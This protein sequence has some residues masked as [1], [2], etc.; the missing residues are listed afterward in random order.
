M[1]SVAG[2]NGP[3]GRRQQENRARISAEAPHSKPQWQAPT[4][5]TR[6][7]RHPGAVSFTRAA[8]LPICSPLCGQ[9]GWPSGECRLSSSA[10]PTV[11]AVLQG[12]GPSRRTA[13]SQPQPAAPPP[14]LSNGVEIM[15]SLFVALAIASTPVSGV[16]AQSRPAPQ[17]GYDGEWNLKLTCGETM[18]DALGRRLST[19]AKG[20]TENIRVQILEN[21]IGRD[22]RYA[23]PANQS[24]F[25]TEAWSGRITGNSFTLTARGEDT[26]G[27]SWSYAFSGR[28]AGAQSLSGEGEQFREPSR[29]VNRQCS[30]EF[31]PV[32]PAPDSLAGIDQNNRRQAAILPQEG[33]RTPPAA[34]PA[35][36]P[37]ATR[38]AAT[39]PR[40][41]VPPV[42]QQAAPA[43]RTA[44]PP[45]TQRAAPAPQAPAQPVTQQGAAAPQA[46]AQPV[47]QLAAPAP[48]A[49]A[50][51]VTQLAAPAPQAPTQP[52]TQLAAPMPASGAVLAPRNLSDPSA[53]ARVEAARLALKDRYAPRIGEE[54]ARNLFLG[55]EGDILIFSNETPQA[56]HFA[57]RFA[58]DG[59]FR[60]DIARICMVQRPG[61]PEP[62]WD[63][64]LKRIASRNN[65]GVRLEPDQLT[66]NPCQIAAAINGNDLVGVPRSILLA[67]GPQQESIIAHLEARRLRLFAQVERSPF[68]LLLETRNANT[69]R[70][71]AELRS[72]VLNGV[73]LLLTSSQQA[74]VCAANTED[75][76]F[77]ARA[78][79]DISAGLIFDRSPGSNPTI[80]LATPDD[81]FIAAKAERCGFI[82]GDG[83]FLR[84]F[85]QALER[86]A[87]RTQLLPVILPRDRVDALLATM[88]AEREAAAAQLSS[89][90]ESDARRVAE[91]QR[92]RTEQEAEAAQRRRLED[93]RQQNDEAARRLELERVRRI[94]ASRGR[95]VVEAFDQRVR[96]H[97]ESVVAEV[98]EV[99]RRTLLGQVLSE[100][101]DRAHR[102]QYAAARMEDAFQAWSRWVLDSA[103]EE[104][105]FGDIRATLEDYGQARWR[106]RQIEAIAVR[107]E[108]PMLNRLI[109]ERRTACTIFVWIND[110]EFSFMRQP[111]SFECTGFDGSFRSWVQ[112]NGFITQWKLPAQ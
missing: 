37:P 58:G 3:A 87:Y 46:P 81:M 74:T 36:L 105:A 29:T 30:V 4:G 70:L 19:G 17:A 90:Q 14:R 6:R 13:D 23:R 31:S 77:V 22:L 89:E 21:R 67:S 27:A 48:Q 18:P 15:R 88:R 1:L 102:V 107:V 33:T 66:S 85:I 84:I 59:Y 99:K 108:F 97:I 40:A 73:V 65:P 104:W 38:Q 83:A 69:Q 56:P 95:T 26:A 12:S 100:Q 72:G 25:V 109:G 62:V 52:A 86:D 80:S 32:N 8:G 110:E 61:V 35:P 60:G 45:V 16:L 91:A 76:E 111:A 20:F 101:E 41:A 82:F 49:P 106:S 5:Q 50:Q 68:N 2:C 103:K 78:T 94:V 75:R 57:R 63:A 34:A 98:A 43:P 79:A 64:Y 9:I 55:N 47:T 44:V 7:G 112:A 53:G 28:A 51:P 71:E 42:T 93:I 24:V 54:V 92:R 96:R 11:V 10:R 39:S